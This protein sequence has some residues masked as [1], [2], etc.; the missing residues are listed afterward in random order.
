MT[1]ECSVKVNE[2]GAEM[3]EIID[4][5]LLDLENKED[6]LQEST[7]NV[8]Y[9][10]TDLPYLVAIPFWLTEFESVYRIVKL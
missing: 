6:I 10:P 4:L 8:C 3:N 1:E 7:L 2:A 5:A 9:S